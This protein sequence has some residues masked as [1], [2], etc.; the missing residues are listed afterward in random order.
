MFRWS[1]SRSRA[2]FALLRRRIRASGLQSTIDELV[3]FTSIDDSSAV[4]LAD[5]VPIDGVNRVAPSV[6]WLV[7]MA[8]TKRPLQEKMTLFWHS[9]LTSQMSVVRD[10]KAMVAQP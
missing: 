4:A 6:W 8:N 7:R 3:N 10:T 1:D 5:Q 9:L 2:D